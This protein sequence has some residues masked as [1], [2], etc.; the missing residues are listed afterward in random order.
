MAFAAAATKAPLSMV[1]GCDIFVDTLSYGF[2][3]LEVSLALLG[4]IED[5]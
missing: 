4:S 2:A 5:Q 3:L 1:F